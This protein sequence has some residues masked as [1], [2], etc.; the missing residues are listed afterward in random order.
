MCVCVCVCVCVCM[1]VK[2]VSRYG[3]CL[4]QLLCLICLCTVVIQVRKCYFFMFSRT[5][6][7][8]WWA[9]IAQ[10]LQRLVT[11][12]RVRGSNPGGGEIFCTG[13]HFL[14]GVPTLLYHGYRVIPWVNLPGRGADH[15]PHLAP[16]VALTRL[17][18]YIY[19]EHPFLMFLDHTQRRSTVGRTPLD[20]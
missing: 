6:Y 7:S 20:E 1:C 10:S 14:W 5:S 3:Y 16:R 15:P 17:M 12:W 19:M 8:Y 9:G 2:Q 11:G 4:E 18:S 13:L